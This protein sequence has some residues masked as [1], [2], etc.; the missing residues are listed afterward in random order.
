VTTPNKMSD[1]GI[2]IP[3]QW[4][5]EDPPPPHPA[6]QFVVLARPEEVVL[7]F[8]FAAPLVVGT[9]QEQM[10]QAKKLRSRGGI[11]PAFVTRVVITAHVA[12]QLHQVLGKQLAGLEQNP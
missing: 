4:D 10:E 2:T 7:T 11:K 8:A 9:P 3:V 1:I 6:N 12:R 5:L